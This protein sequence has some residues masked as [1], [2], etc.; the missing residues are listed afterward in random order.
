MFMW[1]GV[2]VV[3]AGKV[4]HSSFSS[5]AWQSGCVIANTQGFLAQGVSVCIMNTNYG[6]TTPSSQL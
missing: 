3:K 2:K 4:A 1:R 6:A 5:F